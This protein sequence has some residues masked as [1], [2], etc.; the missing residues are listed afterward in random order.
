MAAGIVCALFA[1]GFAYAAVAMPPPH[2]DW[3]MWAFVWLCLIGMVSCI[4]GVHTPVT[5]RII[6]AVI[7]F[8]YVAYVISELSPRGKFFDWSEA[9]PCLI[10]AIRG[11]IFWGLPAGYFMIFGR[12]PGYKRALFEK[13]PDDLVENNEG[14]SMED[15]THKRLTRN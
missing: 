14:S 15:D 5:G 3:I 1:A 2:N 13:N 4:R 6:G 10:N 11:F 7:F 12:L 8:T 9:E